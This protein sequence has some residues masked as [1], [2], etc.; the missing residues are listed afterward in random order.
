MV[1]YAGRPTYTL[2]E[3]A[4]FLWWRT[5]VVVMRW[6]KR[7]TDWAVPIV[8]PLK[9]LWWVPLAVMPFGFVFGLSAALLL[10]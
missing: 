10:G 7:L 4:S 5:V 6:L 2:S 1:N 9:P 3:Q 8:L